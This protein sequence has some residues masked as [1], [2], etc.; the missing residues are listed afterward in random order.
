MPANFVNIVKYKNP[1]L[2]L[3]GE[4]DAQTPLADALLISQK[5]K[6]AGHTDFQIE[7]FPGL[8]HGFSPHKGP[9]GITPTVGPIEPTVVDTINQW[10]NSKF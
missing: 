2:M 5:L 4:I 9:H 7:T 10:I 3:H 6:Q 8:G 1:I